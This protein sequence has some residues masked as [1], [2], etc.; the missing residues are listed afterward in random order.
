VEEGTPDAN[1]CAPGL[2]EL[3]LE[4]KAVD[5]FPKGLDTPVRVPHFTPQQRA[6]LA[7]RVRAGGHAAVLLQVERWYVLLGGAYA[8]R[9]LGRVPARVLDENGIHSWK[10]NFEENLRKGVEHLVGFY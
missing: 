2:G 10:R 4:L 9:N 5:H 3:W 6:W 1:L 7:E 8:V